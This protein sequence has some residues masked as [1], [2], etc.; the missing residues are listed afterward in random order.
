MNLFS[1]PRFLKILAEVYFP[2]RPYAIREARLGERSFRLLQVEGRRLITHWPFVDFFEPLA[3]GEEAHPIGAS[4]MPKA[5][6]GR[7][8][9]DEWHAQKLGERFQASPLVDW[10]GFPSYE[11]F[12]ALVKTRRSNVFADGRRRRRRIEEQ[13]GRLELDFED[14]RSGSFESCLR[15]KSAQ[16][17]AS[18]A[19]D[20]FAVPGHAALF[21]RLAQEGLLKVASLSANGR[22]LAAHFGVL[23]DGR[24]YYWIP[25]YDPECAAFSPGRLL[26]DFMLKESWRRGR[27]FDF[28]IGDEAYKWYYATHVRLI[29][30]LGRAPLLLRARRGVGRAARRVLSV[31]PPV[32]QLA[33]RLRRRL[34]G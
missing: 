14:P 20:Y 11:S 23:E 24:F 12:E 5:C 17:L 19:P 33:L 2:G 7:V 27:E 4:Y 22:L 3:R 32:Y 16:Y 28:L 26:L 30:P 9:C 34:G 25:A 6:Q 10:S 29:G 31:S 13:F 21:R 18:G 1:D 15:W 8:T